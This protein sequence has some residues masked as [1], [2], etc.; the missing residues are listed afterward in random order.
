MHVAVT[1]CATAQ[2]C[3]GSQAWI[4]R[5]FLLYFSLRCHYILMFL[6]FP[7]FWKG[8]YLVQTKDLVQTRVN[9]LK[10]F[11]KNL[12]K[13]MNVLLNLPHLYTKFYGQI[14]LTLKVTKKTNFL[15]TIMV[16]MHLK[17][18]FFVTSRVRRIWPWNFIYRWCNLRSTFMIFFRIFW[19]FI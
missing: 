4:Y 17:F 7:L 13:I 11:Q 15:T 8:T 6:L 19:N 18:V 3:Q 12:K 2:S 1:F 5:V 10:K 9:L 16:Q 14:H